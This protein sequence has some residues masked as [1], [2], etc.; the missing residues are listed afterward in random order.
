MDI[1]MMMAEFRVMHP[2]FQFCVLMG[3]TV[4]FFHVI[5]WMIGDRY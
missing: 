4:L 5:Y 2:V 3:G 1:Y